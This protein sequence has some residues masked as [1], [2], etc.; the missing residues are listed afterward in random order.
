MALPRCV[1]LAGQRLRAH[2]HSPAGENGGKGN[3]AFPVIFGKTAEEA[4]PSKWI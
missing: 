2:Q 1:I 4:A 3:Q